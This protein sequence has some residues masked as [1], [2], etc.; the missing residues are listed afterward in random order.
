MSI[1][2][3]AIGIDIDGVL[4]DSDRIFRKYIKKYFGFNLTRQDVKDFF[5]EK[6]LGIPQKEME[7]FWQDFTDKKGWQEIPLL[8]GAK[9][10]LDYLKTKYQIIIITSRP[11]A[12]KDLTLKWL[13]KNDIPYDKIY[14]VEEKKGENKLQKILSNG[15]LIKTFIEDRLDI[16]LEFVKEGIKVLLFD[17]PWN[18]TEQKIDSNIIRINGWKEALSYL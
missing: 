13:E 9:T 14:F 12:I 11:D 8:R 4:G 1:Y 16:S 3:P 17:Y 18:K 15:L 2:K 7:K 6:V 5:Y 10:A